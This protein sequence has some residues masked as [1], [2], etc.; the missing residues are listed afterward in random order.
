ME[1]KKHNNT[2]TKLNIGKIIIR[3]LQILLILIVLTFI[4]AYIVPLKRDLIE[5]S[6]TDLITEY[7]NFMDIEDM[8]IYVED[9]HS[10]DFLQ[11]PDG[12]NILIFI[13]GMG[14]S[15]FSWRENMMFFAE[16][17]FRIIAIDLKGFG[18]SHKDFF[19]DYSHME[20]A[21]IISLVMDNLNIEKSVLIGHSM[22]ASVITH[23]A[24]IY[25]D[26]VNKMIL[27]DASI[28]EKP[29]Y[30]PGIFFHFHPLVRLGRH[31]TRYTISMDSFNKT[32]LSAY[33]RKEIVTDKITEGYYNR[34]VMGD[35]ALSFFAM[36]RD[37]N[38]NYINFNLSDISKPVLIIWGEE[39]PWISVSEGEKLHNKFS[40]STLE[41]ISKAGHL[42]M[43]EYP[44]VF[45]RIIIDN[46]SE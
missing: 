35:F 13:H 21:R 44:D 37:M 27:V 16:N 8:K 22:G 6:K 19:S 45:N 41:I 23:F 4:I 29:Q 46:L 11:S 20:Q 28:K 5:V 31:I 26:K 3:I 43:E 25:P 32:L 33:H 39:D 40:K 24:N 7:G 30:F 10:S 34:F 38:R 36:S 1:N 17:G 2:D 14:G 9:L 15:T 18:L 12:A 42:P